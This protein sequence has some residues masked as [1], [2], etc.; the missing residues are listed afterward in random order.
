MG[1]GRKKKN[2]KNKKEEVKNMPKKSVKVDMQH[3]PLYPPKKESDM[4]EMLMALGTTVVCVLLVV[5]IVSKFSYMNQVN[6]HN[7]YGSNYDTANQST[8]QEPQPEEEEPQE[9]E[10]EGA[11]QVSEGEIGTQEEEET[12]QKDEPEED[13]EKDRDYIFA[14]SGSR[15]LST[16]DLEG[17]SAEELS[18]A[19]NEIYARHGRRFKDAGLQS[20]F[21]SKPWYNGT[22][23]PDQFSEGMLNEYEKKNAETILSYERSKGYK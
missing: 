15:Y 16:S 5:L 7:S 9:T 21:D 19:R 23:E 22:I 2:K 1:F 11:A 12:E 18:W 8:Q 13:S 4:Q 6:A 17:L 3:N 10:P 20:Y 14:D